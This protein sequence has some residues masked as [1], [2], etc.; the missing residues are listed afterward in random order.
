[1]EVVSLS[2]WALC[3]MHVTAPGSFRYAAASAD[4]NHACSCYWEQTREEAMVSICVC[5]ERTASLLLCVA[6]AAIN[7][8]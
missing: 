3:V 5:N 4:D 7:F 8:N 6:L 2:M 1:M